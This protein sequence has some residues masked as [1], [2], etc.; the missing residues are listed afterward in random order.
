MAKKV[1]RDSTGKRVHPYVPE[2]GD[3]YRR[4]K[5]SRRDFLH[6]VTMLGVSAGAAY[7]FADKVDGIESLSRPMR[8]RRV[9]R[10]VPPCACKTCPTRPSSTGSRAPTKLG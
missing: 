10:Y 5:V 1:Y 2:I 9:A 7:A 4:G 8:H 3:L 6:T